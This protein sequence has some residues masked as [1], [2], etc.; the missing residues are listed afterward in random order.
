MYQEQL[1]R[2]EPRRKHS[3]Y[4]RYYWRNWKTF[5]LSS[6]H[7]TTSRNFIFRMHFCFVVTRYFSLRISYE[8]WKILRVIIQMSCNFI[9]LVASPSFRLNLF[10][11]KNCMTDILICYSKGPSCRNMLTVLRSKY[12]W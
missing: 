7:I 11:S 2:T 8:K 3:S 9:L 10:Y 4:W 12:I 6:D 5:R 1:S